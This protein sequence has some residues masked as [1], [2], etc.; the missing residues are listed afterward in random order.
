MLLHKKIVTLKIP[1]NTSKSN[2]HPL[3]KDSDDIM[4]YSNLKTLIN[5]CIHGET[6]LE[7]L[8]YLFWKIYNLM[9]ILISYSIK[10]KFNIILKLNTNIF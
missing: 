5:H 10:L 6:I 4:I 2:I 7:I 8:Q 1:F 3:N 9:I